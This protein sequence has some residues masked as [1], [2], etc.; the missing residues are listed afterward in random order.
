VI[1]EDGGY[2]YGSFVACPHCDGYG[3]LQ[4][5]AEADQACPVCLV[6]ENPFGREGYLA[7]PLEPMDADRIYG[8]CLPGSPCGALV[9]QEWSGD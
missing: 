5:E 2:D 1:D 6:R 7:L 4:A 8:T 3:W 9:N